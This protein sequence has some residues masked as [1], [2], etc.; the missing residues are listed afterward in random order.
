MPENQERLAEICNEIY[1]IKDFHNTY[2]PMGSFKGWVKSRKY[3]WPIPE[4]DFQKTYAKFIFDTDHLRSRRHGFINGT[5]VFQQIH[6]DYYGYSNLKREGRQALKDRL[7][8]LVDKFN[9]G[10]GPGANKAFM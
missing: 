1:T 7:Q 8:G 10:S 5:L 6:F 3:R 9:M 2:C 4:K